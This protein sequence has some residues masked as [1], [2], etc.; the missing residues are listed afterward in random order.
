MTRLKGIHWLAPTTMI[1]ALLGGS[2]LALSHHLFYASLDRK[3]V[4]TG[5]Y[6]FARTNL[7][8]QQFNMR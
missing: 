3:A 6:H 5:S 4:Q 2:L 7:A 8:K 1:L